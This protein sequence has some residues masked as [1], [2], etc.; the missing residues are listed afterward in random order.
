VVTVRDENGAALGSV[1]GPGVIEVLGAFP[2]SLFEQEAFYTVECVWPAGGIDDIAYAGSGFGSTVTVD[3]VA[4]QAPLSP[5]PQIPE[6]PQ[7]PVTLENI[8]VQ[9]ATTEPW[10]NSQNGIYQFEYRVTI[11]N[12]SDV[13]IEDWFMVFTLPTE[14]ITRV[15]GNAK[16]G[17]EVADG[18][19]RIENPRYNNVKTD[20]IQPGES[21]TFG[22]HALG[23]G[24]EPITGIRIGGSNVAE[25][26]DIT[27]ETALG[28][29]VNG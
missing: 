9:Y 13:P 26:T 28:A 10:M 20:T 29:G 1:T 24:I 16:L 19:Y 25:T 7:D 23:L 3:A 17:T 12:N 4:S 2:L 21:V 27:L 14:R 6:E 22:G 8:T 15:F 5:S 18:T 11:T